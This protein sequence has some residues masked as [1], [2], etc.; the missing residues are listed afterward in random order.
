MTSKEIIKNAKYCSEGDCLHCTGGG[1]Q[2]VERLL[3]DLLGI[4][5]LQGEELKMIKN[6]KEQLEE[7]NKNLRDMSLVDYNL[8]QI[9]EKINKII[10]CYYDHEETETILGLMASLIPLV[11]KDNKYHIAIERHELRP[12]FEKNKEIEIH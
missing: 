4:V 5:C 11:D 8:S 3:K 12:Y 1:G 9:L 10:K 7:E 2:C 6:R